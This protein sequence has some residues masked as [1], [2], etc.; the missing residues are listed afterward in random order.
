MRTLSIKPLPLTLAVFSV[1][2]MQNAMANEPTVQLE[3]MTIELDRQGTKLKSNVV[4]TQ[5]KNESTETDLRGL[6]KGEPA[7]DFGGGNGASQ[8]ITIR[9]MGQNSIDVK[10]DNAYS[11][12]QILYHQGRFMLDPALVKIVSVQKGAG[13]ASAG[14]GATNGAIVARTVDASDLLKGTNKD[15]G[16]KVNTSYS[17]NDEHSYGVAGFGRVGAFDFVLSGNRTEQDNY[18][19]GKGYVSPVDGGDKVHYSALDKTN[20]LA[21]AGLTLGDH[22]FVLSHF[23]DEN[24][25][26]R[27]IREEF[28]WFDG[29]STQDPQYRKLSLENTNLEYIG[30]NLGFADEVTANVYRMKNVRKSDDDALN[31][32]TGRFS[33][34][35]KTEV[36]TTGANLNFDNYATDNVLLKY[37]VNYRHQETIPNTLATGVINQEKTDVG[38]YT[39]AIGDIGPVT[40]TAGVRYDHFDFTA[41]DG[42][43]ASH[44]DLNPSIGLIWQATTDLSF[45]AN[46]NHATR[47]PRMIDALLAHGGRGVVSV[48]DNIKPE[49]AKNSEIGFNYNRGNFTLS[50][51]YFWQEIDNL[52]NSGSVARHNVGTYYSGINNVGYAKNK[53][54]EINTAYQHK[55]FTTR[56]GVADSDPKFYSERDDAGNLITFNSS[57]FAQRLGRIWTADVSYRFDNPNLE[58]G[59]RHRLAEDAYGQS[60]WMQDVAGTDPRRAHSTTTKREGYNVTDIYA[61]WKPFNNEQ[62][63][64]NFAINNVGDEYYRSHS[65]GAGTNSLPAVGRE[66]RV[67]VNYTF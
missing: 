35:N 39:E 54:F 63:N 31:N 7:I 61:N 41:M 59:V 5:N 19:A 18:K 52:L 48:A 46:H 62:M 20:Y 36:Q 58:L 1:L 30:K 34:T 38:L 26:T 47:S 44:G 9:G 14:I 64:V 13:S 24:K 23:K 21:K 16:V 57:S 32:Y 3:Q 27:N 37:G 51:S 40:A 17:T 60:A 6:L 65:Q 28:D 53:G 8:Y 12:S 50:G 42:K 45:S 43:K 2:A 29:T 10:V 67:G 49:K 15:W 33:G 25:G 4:T 66:F 11:D 22:R 56:F 55:G